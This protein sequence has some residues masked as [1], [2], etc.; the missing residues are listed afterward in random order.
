MSTFAKIEKTT[1]L[2]DDGVHPATIIGVVELPDEVN[3]FSGKSQ[4]KIAI[5]FIFNG[6]TY[7]TKEEKT[8]PLTTW[9]I[10]TMSCY[11]KAKLYPILRWALKTTTLTGVDS[12]ELL[13]K[14]V[15]LMIENK[16]KENKT[17]IE[18]TG[19]TKPTQGANNEGIDLVYFEEGDEVP[20]GLPKWIEE[21]I[22]SASKASIGEIFEPE[23]DDETTRF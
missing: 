8:F 1:T 12:K 7:K 13:G 6:K 21:K 11:E 19:A 3:P 15:N 18:V 17:Y 16:V 22:T 14:A 9:K 10:Y 20:N 4:K 23:T 5:R 2:L